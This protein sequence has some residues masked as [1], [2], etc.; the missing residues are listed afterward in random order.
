VLVAVF[1][2]VFYNVVFDTPVSPEKVFSEQA[3]FDN[4]KKVID[5]AA[6]PAYIKSVAYGRIIMFRMESISSYKSADI[7]AAFKYA[8]GY[9]VDGNLKT[10]YDEILKESTIDLVTIGGNAAVATEPISSAN[11][12]SASSI[13]EKVQG[14]IS[15]DNAVYNKSNPGVPIGYTVFY[16]KDNSIA[17][18]GYT[19]EYTA[20]EC[21]TTKITTTIT[22]YL[23]QFNVTQDC[24]GWPLGD[25]TFRYYINILDQNNNKLISTYDSGWKDFGDGGN[26][27]I[28]Q[29][30]T[31]TLNRTYGTKFTLKLTCYELDYDLFGNSHYDDR[32]NGRVGSVTF[33]YNSDGSWSGGGGGISYSSTYTYYLYDG[34]SN[35]NVNLK[36]SV[37]AD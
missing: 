11:S 27:K 26:Q 12:N 19:T 16:L 23:D 14:I 28:N 25:G 7:E 9:S 18:L 21:V 34:E 20:K 6:A 13:L 2:Q 29:T 15:G 4:V 36:Y 5:D 30:K 35:C 1:K 3:S 31:L 17:K 24:D 22:V 10:T 37:K 32:M 8:A 33:S